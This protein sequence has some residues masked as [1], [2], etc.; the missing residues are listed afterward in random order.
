MTLVECPD[1]RKQVDVDD[2]R[3]ETEEDGLDLIVTCPK[4]KTQFVVQRVKQ[5]RIKLKR[6]QYAFVKKK[7]GKMD[8]IKIGR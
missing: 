8:R 6:A 4:C 1:C 2:R 3:V 7:D 5:L